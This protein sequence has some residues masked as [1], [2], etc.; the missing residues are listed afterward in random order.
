[1]AAEWCSRGRRQIRQPSSLERLGEVRDMYR[2]GAVLKAGLLLGLAEARV[3]AL[4]C[5]STSS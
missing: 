1:M 4:D 2:I 3:M 5:G